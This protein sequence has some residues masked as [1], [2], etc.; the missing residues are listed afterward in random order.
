M[1]Q[2]Q[3]VSDTHLEMYDKYNEG[4][5]TPAMFIKPS[6]PYLALCGDIGI[7]DLKAYG[8]FLSWCSNN[9]VK[10]FVLAG[11]HEFYNY[12]C[13]T[14]TDISTKIKLIEEIVSRFDNVYFLNKSSHYIQDQNLRILGCS[15]WTDTS[16][17]D[18]KAMLMYMNDTKQVYISDSTTIHPHDVTRLHM[19]QR[20]W[21]RDEI[22]D[23]EKRGESVVVLTHHLPTYKLIHPKYH[24]HPLNMCFASNCEDLIQAPVKG[25]ICGHSHTAVKLD[26][27]GVKC[28]MNPYGYPGEICDTRDR[29]AVLT[30]D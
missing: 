13:A 11:N 22:R 12:R 10:V 9:F 2:I 4:V 26:L 24:N 28:V 20:E 29:T 25:W 5:I 1:F 3:Y 19:D 14:K 7:P 6:A 17:G 16:P 15:L 30:V 8:I 23:A 27:N 21:L 18:V